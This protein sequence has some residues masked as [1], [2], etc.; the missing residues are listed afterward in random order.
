MGNKTHKRA[1]LAAAIR[2]AVPIYH[3]KA[4]ELVE[5]ILKHMCRT[6]SGRKAVKIQAFGIFHILE[7]SERLGRNPG[8]GEEK[9]ISA[10]H[11]LKFRPSREMRRRVDT[12]PSC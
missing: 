10:R 7:K 11:V 9:I 2:T 6:L 12:D 8:T 1:D 4:S 3:A 5:S